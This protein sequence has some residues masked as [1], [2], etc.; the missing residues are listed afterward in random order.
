MREGERE[1]ECER[2][3]TREQERKSEHKIEEA[4]LEPVENT[5][6]EDYTPAEETHIRAT[7]N[8]YS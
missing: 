6:L 2:K 5:S 8:A 4:T 3:R 7:I 1:I